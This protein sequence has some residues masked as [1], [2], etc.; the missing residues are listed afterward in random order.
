MVGSSLRLSIWLE[1]ESAN[2]SSFSSCN[3]DEADIERT[4]SNASESTPQGRH[5]LEAAAGDGS[6]AVCRSCASSTAI[7]AADI[8]CGTNVEIRENLGDRGYGVFIMFGNHREKRVRERGST[9]DGL[10]RA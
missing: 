4:M 3:C 8:I 5:D 10:R 9:W 6:R 7:N 1:S 2:S